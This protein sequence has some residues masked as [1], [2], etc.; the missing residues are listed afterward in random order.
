M[1][2]QQSDAPMFQTELAP[3]SSFLGWL[4][5]QI[6]APLPLVLWSVLVNPLEAA[7]A[8][9]LQVSRDGF[10]LF[11]YLP[12]GWTLSFRL[13]MLVQR[14]FPGAIASGRRI[15]MVPVFL[16]ALAFCWDVAQFSI[17]FAFAEVFYPG[18]GGESQW[19]FLLMTCP[20][21]SA[22]AYSLGMIWSTR[23]QASKASATRNSRPD[24]A[25][26]VTHSSWL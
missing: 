5:Q 2:Q 9:W 10:D 13:A 6:A 3:E 17:S 25:S 15:W 20:T 18:P 8:P 26:G 22:I 23:R 21:V 12:I 1:D 19:A 14:I 7:V 11:L 24:D 16:L 4:I